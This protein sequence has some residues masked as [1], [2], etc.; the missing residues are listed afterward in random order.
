MPQGPAHLLTHLRRRLPQQRARE[1]VQL[2]GAFG[3]IVNGREK[4]IA[5]L[6]LD[7]ELFPQLARKAHLERFAEFAFAAREFPQ[8]FKVNAPVPACQKE[9]AVAFDDCSGDHDR[10]VSGRWSSLVVGHSSPVK[11]TGCR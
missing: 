9:A 6:R 3:V 5:D 11:A 8:S 7:G 4:F 1:E 2:D 10:V